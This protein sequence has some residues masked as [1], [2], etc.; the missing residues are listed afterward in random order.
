MAEPSRVP[1]TTLVNCID[2]GRRSFSMLCKSCAGCCWSWLSPLKRVTAVATGNQ[3]DIHLFNLSSARAFKRRRAAYRQWIDI[4][5]W[6][7]S[8]VKWTWL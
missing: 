8:I 6:G 5:I 7:L 2:E 1:T 3:M 4:K